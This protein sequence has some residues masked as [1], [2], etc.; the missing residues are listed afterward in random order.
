MAKLKARRLHLHLLLQP[1]SQ[2]ATF[3]EFHKP[4]SQKATYASS[5][6]K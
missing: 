3:T 1:K 6:L 5:C 2:K 4:N